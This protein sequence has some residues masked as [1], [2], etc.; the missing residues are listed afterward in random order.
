[1]KRVALL[2]LFMAIAT[3]S[4]RSQTVDDF[5][6][7]CPSAE[8]ISAIDKDL[9]LTFE[10]EDPSAAGGFVCRASD[11][12]KDLTRMQE[13]V[14]Q[15]LRVFRTI[16][17]DAPLPWTEKPV[18]DWL[19]SS[20]KGIRFNTTLFGGNCC[21]DDKIMEVGL[22]AKTIF[23]SNLWLT[24]NGSG[25]YDMM[26][27]IIHEAQHSNSTVPHNACP[28]GDN[29]DKNVA[30]LGAYAVQLYWWEWLAEHTDS[31]FAP[32]PA[33]Y[34]SVRDSL[35]YKRFGESSIVAIRDQNF[36]NPGE[37]IALVPSN[38]DFS[39]KSIESTTSRTVTMTQTSSIAIFINHVG[40]EG[41]DAGDFEIATDGCTDKKLMAQGW[42]T[43]FSSFISCTVTVN[44]VPKTVGTKS[45]KLTT[46]DTALNSPHSV[47]LT[48]TAVEK[49][50]SLTSVVSGA[51]FAPGKKISP[52]EHITLF[53]NNLTRDE[54]ST[55]WME[56]KFE[57]AGASVKICGI[58]SRMIY[59]SPTQLNVVTPSDLTIGAECDVVASSP[60]GT[61]S[62][63]TAIPV[64]D[65]NLALFGFYPTLRSTGGVFP[66][67][68]PI[69]TNAKWQLLGPPISDLNPTVVQ[70][71]RGEVIV[72]WGTGCGVRF[73]DAKNTPMTGIV[74]SVMPK[75]T[76][77]GIPAK[78]EWAGLAPG[79]DA[80]C[81]FN[82]QV[83]SD[84]PPG[85]PEVPVPLVMEE[86]GE[87]S[88]LY[89]R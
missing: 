10:G 86:G 26:S 14:Y 66:I 83:P 89:V 65:Q 62:F 77:G 52:R 42:F 12:S 36:C 53:G 59:A 11:G 21:G 72:A 30:L 58:S 80:L 51:S 41:K 70:P 50:A 3:L 22:G 18:Y 43:D 2:M 45:A 74:M 78:V 44:F 49:K 75:I 85:S 54:K 19:V 63:T 60:Y 73:P 17:F 32:T 35:Y 31:W 25:I 20:V 61:A 87:S 1:M 24:S 88:S 64:A 8:E 55:D 46:R 33:S 56:P 38:R 81:Q 67:Q 28:G 68:L 13:R 37:H 47:T 79:F 5:I 6:A 39:E 40:I 23:G 27:T 84:L 7:V 34:D 69:I 48:G 29:K 57:L 16:K 76:V 9:T 82:F 15:A 71:K 4:L